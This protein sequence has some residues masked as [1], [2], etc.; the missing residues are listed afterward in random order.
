MATKTR[1]FNELRVRARDP[2]WDAGVAEH[3]RAMED[4]LALADLLDPRNL[5]QV[6]RAERLGNAQGDVS[7]LKSCSGAYLSTL[8]SYVEALGGH[9]E[10]V[11]VFGSERI[12][13]A[14]SRPERTE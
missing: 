6:D 7:R 2:D 5:T 11:A 13:V 14:A 8:C 12:T 9:L 3:R 10:L 4:A 1:S